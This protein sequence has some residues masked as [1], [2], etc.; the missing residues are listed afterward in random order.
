MNLK[1]LVLAASL[2]LVV[3][4]VIFGTDMCAQVGQTQQTSTETAGQEAVEGTD[5]QSP[6][7]GGVRNVN[8]NLRNMKKDMQKTMDQRPERLDRAA[9]Q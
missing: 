7:E 1:A 8:E 5:V 6:T 4:G 3:V 9:G 2:A